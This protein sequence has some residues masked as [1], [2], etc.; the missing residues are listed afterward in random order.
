MSSP[1]PFEEEFEID[2][3]DDDAPGAPDQRKEPRQEA[4]SSLRGTLEYRDKMLAVRVTD[5]SL[6]GA[7]VNAR[8]RLPLGAECVLTLHMTVCGA[9]YELKMKSRVRH[10]DAENNKTYSAGLQ[11]IDMSPDTRDTLA[12]LIR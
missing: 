2:L 1:T 7:G 8:S 11:F 6:Q 5:L 12:L 10:C 4:S 9:D 3:T